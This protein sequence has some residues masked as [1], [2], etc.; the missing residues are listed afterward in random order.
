MWVYT[1]EA[2]NDQPQIIAMFNSL[3]A[4][5]LSH[6]QSNSSS[7]SSTNNSG[8]TPH[9]TSTTSS[10]SQTTYVRMLTEL[11]PSRPSSAT[12]TKIDRPDEPRTVVWEIRAHATGVEGADLPGGFGLGG[13]GTMVPQSQDEGEMKG[14]AIWVMGRR[15]GEN[16]SDEGNGQT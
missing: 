13:G 2:A 16:M 10:K 3:L 4:P 6:H 8:S 14:K 12:G 5:H 7:N 15:I 11:P 1:D 9:T